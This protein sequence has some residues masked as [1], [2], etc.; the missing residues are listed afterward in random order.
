MLQN[1]DK[2]KVVVAKGGKRFI[3]FFINFARKS[4]SSRT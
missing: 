2:H 4:V 1:Y 3:Y